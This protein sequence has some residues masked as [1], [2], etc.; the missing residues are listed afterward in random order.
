MGPQQR[1]DRRGVDGGLSLA[2]VRDSV[3]ATEQ[4]KRQAGR[5]LRR[6]STMDAMDVVRNLSFVRL[7]CSVVITR[8]GSG[9]RREDV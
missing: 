3:W 5:G 6:R 4:V 7:A 9:H 2:V 1:V 8:R